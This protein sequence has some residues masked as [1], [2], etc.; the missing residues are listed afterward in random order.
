MNI[1]KLKGRIVENGLNNSTFAKKINLPVATF[2]RRLENEGK[3]FTIGE[4]ERIVD[5]LNLSSQDAID[6][7]YPKSRKNENKRRRYYERIKNF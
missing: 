1:L 4:I 3:D 7:F 5:V 2:Y 6:I